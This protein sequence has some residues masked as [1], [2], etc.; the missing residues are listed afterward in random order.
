MRPIR[1]LIG[2]GPDLR[3]IVI[4]DG[5][6]P[7]HVHLLAV[8]HEGVEHELTL[9]KALRGR[10]FRS[11]GVKRCRQGGGFGRGLFRPGNGEQVERIL[12]AEVGRIL[13]FGHPKVIFAR[14]RA[15]LYLLA[16]LKVHDD[17][18]ALAGAKE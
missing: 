17:F 1:V 9:F 4:N 14:H 12:E 7:R 13:V 10:G 11:G 16:G 5:I 2:H 15:Q 8:D 3:G 6:H 18:G